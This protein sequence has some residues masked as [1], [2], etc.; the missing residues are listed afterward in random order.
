MCVCVHMKK[1]YAPLTKR[2]KNTHEERE[3]WKLVA[4]VGWLGLEALHGWVLK[5]RCS[6]GL[7]PW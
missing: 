5:A 2:E 1:E 7:L 6:L 4:K 3:E